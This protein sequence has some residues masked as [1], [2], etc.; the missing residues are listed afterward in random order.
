MRRDRMTVPS[1]AVRR[2]A[3]PCL[4]V[5][6]LVGVPGT[7]GGA[8][9]DPAAAPWFEEVTA[10]AGLATPHHVRRFRNP[11]ARIMDGYTA[12]GAAAA[13]ADF[14]GD[15]FEDV[16]LT[17]SAEDGRNHLYRNRGDFT[18]VDV[19]AAAGVAAGNDAD[20]ASA[21]ALWF[22]ADG[23]GDDD[24]LVVRFGR[25]LLY[26]NRGDGTFRD[27]TRDAG[28]DRRL[29]S[30]TAIA[31]DVDRDGDLDLVL[32]NYFAP[33]DLF[34]P[35][36]PRFF[37][38]SFESAD[39]GG[40][41][42]LYRNDGHA[43]FTDVTA[44]AGL[45]A[46]SGWTLDVGHAD[47]DADG[48]DDLYVASDFGSD[49]LYLNDGDGTFTDATAAA[50]GIDTK[51]GM[52]VD[53]GDFDG[54]GRL[55]VFVTNITDAY[56]R[57]G[58]F[59]WHNDGDG[60]FTDVA[61]EAGVWDTG[62]GWGGKF[63]DYDND[64]WLDLYTVN[65]WVS[66]GPEDYVLDIFSLIV[67]PQVDLTDARNWPPMGGK[68]FS[69]YQRDHLFHNEGGTLFQDAGARHGVDSIADGRGVA[70]ADFDNDGRL[71]LLVTNAGAAPQLWRNRL[72][73]GAHWV[74]FRL[75][76]GP[77]NRDAIGAQVRV[78][79]AGRE[80]LAFVDGGNGFAGQSSRRLHFGLGDATRIERLDVRWPSGRR[81]V[82][83][84]LAADRIY[85]LVEGGAPEPWSPPPPDG[86]GAAAPARSPA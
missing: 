61:R 9:D 33:V 22:D 18:F 5:A 28:L 8:A 58:N 72:P 62:W 56:M 11:Y 69:G 7:A 65:G 30:I 48:D 70:I 20:D 31:F 32:G 29:N 80:R 63:F 37:P 21:D 3:V 85:R 4:L 6:A 36:D 86:P 50:L 41:V 19:A 79:A 52:N 78:T 40:G 35:D 77:S 74:S 73:T 45:A 15:G 75:E 60:T 51:K 42:T 23:D 27:A 43:H 24:L 64:G 1:A 67:K 44:A 38:E 12:L 14:D 46:H 55:D 53:W 17:D 57:E 83:T 10:A 25:S 2:A 66:A 71:D 68:T 49:R 39:N 84:G 47:A 81:Q 34:A 16:F 54:D 82:F 76:G 26:E 13:V 59:L